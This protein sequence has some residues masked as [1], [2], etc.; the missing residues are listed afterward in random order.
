MTH[1]GTFS[2]SGMGLNM[3]GGFSPGKADGERT[4]P[5]HRCSFKSR[6]IFAN[7]GEGRSNNERGAYKDSSFRTFIGRRPE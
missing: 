2:G 7:A 4:I 6:R 1:S 3:V 5:R